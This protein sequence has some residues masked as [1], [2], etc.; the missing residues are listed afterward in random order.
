MGHTGRNCFSGAILTQET[1]VFRS[2]PVIYN[3]DLDTPD[4]TGP[5]STGTD[6]PSGPSMAEADGM[7]VKREDLVK[8]GL[9]R[10]IVDIMFHA[11]CPATV[12]YIII[13]R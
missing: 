6:M 8:S 1:L 7:E 10:E 2:S 3:K 9:P 13:S 12:E 5:V 11:R 4:S